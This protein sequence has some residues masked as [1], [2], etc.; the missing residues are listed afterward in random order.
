M[1]N[2]LLRL[3]EQQMKEKLFHNYKWYFTTGLL[4]YETFPPIFVVD[5]IALRWHRVTFCF[6]S[7]Q[8]VF[9]DMMISLQTLF[10]NNDCDVEDKLELPSNSGVFKFWIGIPWVQY[11]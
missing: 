6:Q 5:P 11:L 1:F 3:C 8:Q 10:P 4:P 7:S 2:S 9:E